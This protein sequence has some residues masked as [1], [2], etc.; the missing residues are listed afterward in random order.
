MEILEG[1]LGSSGFQPHGF[2][3][4]W[5]TALVWLHVLSDLLIALS[6]FAIPLILLHFIRK[7]RDLPF[8]WMFALFG[9]FIVA[10]GTTHLMEVWNL[11]HADYW[12]AGAIKAV[13]AAASLPTAI[14]L[15][16]IVPQ[17]L[18]LPNNQRWIQVNAAL[19]EE[20][21]E[22]RETELD[23]RIS[24]ANYRENAELLDLTHDAIFVRNLKAELVFWNKGAERLYG[25][26]KEE[27][28]GK[29]S[30]ELL[31]T[32]FPIPLKE[33]EEKVYASGN[34]EGELIHRQ[35]NGEVVIVASRW[36]LRMDSSG[37]PT[38]ILESNR[39]ITQRRREEGKFRALLE[40]APD[41]MIIVDAEG[42][43]QLANAQVESVFG[44]AKSEL[45]G[46]PV[47]MLVPERMRARHGGHRH[48][49]F[50]APKKRGMGAGL[51]LY[52][53]R[54][55]RTEFPVEISL[56]PLEGP[57]GMVVTA[58]I[59]DVSE[60]KRTAEALK[61]SEE[62]LQ[63]AV[64]AAEL[65][66]WDLDIMRDRVFR[67]LRHDEIF[68]YESLQPEWGME[69]AQSHVIPEDRERYRLSFTK[70][71]DSNANEFLLECRINRVND[72][73][74]RWI[75]AQGR[76]YRDEGGQPVR[77]M[78]VVADITDR[79]EAEKQLEQQQTELARSN[80]ELNAAN[81]ELEAFSYSVSHDLRAPLRSIDGFSL[82]LL[83]DYSEKLD[84]DGKKN[85][86]RVRAATQ[87]MGALIDDLLG[88]ARVTR[89]SMTLES[90]DVSA[91]AGEVIQKLREQQPG[92]TVEARIEKGLVG[93]ADARLLRIVLENLLGNAW[94]FTSKREV[95]HIEFGT[96]QNGNGAA[97]F[98]RDDGAGFDPAYTERLFGA[99]QR[100]HSTSEF[101][102]TGIGLA[103]VQRII[104]RH[105]GRIWAESS[106]GNGATF[107]FTLA[108]TS[109]AIAPASKEEEKV[110]A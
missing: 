41:A 103:T 78:G 93:K 99:F 17:A 88:L 94:K 36:A 6:Y 76:V 104:R 11:W 90:V 79:K 106:V 71:W 37:K 22:R 24:E 80:A 47:E 96:A 33:I 110:H 13:T 43:V 38:A 83:E 5:N 60:R 108:D 59:R 44:Y 29:T 85:L 23:L 74:L 9:V 82:A 70:A 95:A 4:Q 50:A 20:V 58:A 100:L 48:S 54:K 34:W 27:V 14:L 77:M 64:E 40:A 62:R 86:E 16:R 56:S 63:M 8:S 39:D 107:Y 2:C 109:P 67:S 35:R 55:D 52:G 26:T 42:R 68:G 105:G 15:A 89:K 18:D 10:C 46:K 65:G 51:E 31:H 19:R 81:Q 72:H 84:A 49:F 61:A 57:E 12:L 101:P 45:L 1:L 97:F 25:W 28:R 32:V 30:H 75:S 53:L 21:R 3:Y 92:R 73:A 102:G 7:R 87:R 69:I 66:V 91:L 98:V